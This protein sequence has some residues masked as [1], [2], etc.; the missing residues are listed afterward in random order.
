M[1]EL[2]TRAVENFALPTNV[3]SMIEESVNVIPAYSRIDAR[4][5]DCWSRLCSIVQNGPCVVL[6]LIL[7]NGEERSDFEP[8]QL[9]TV[10]H[11]RL[12]M[13][14]WPV[15]GLYPDPDASVNRADRAALRGKARAPQVRAQPPVRRGCA[16]RP[17]HADLPF[18]E[19]ASRTLEY[20][21]VDG[22]CVYRLHADGRP[23]CPVSALKAHLTMDRS[24]PEAEDAAPPSA[25]ELAAK[26][27]AS[28]PAAELPT[29]SSVAL[30]KRPAHET[31]PGAKSSGD[32]P[33]LDSPKTGRGTEGP[34]PSR[35]PSSLP[36][37][38]GD[39]QE[40]SASHAG[41]SVGQ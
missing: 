32:S 37:K 18:D 31:N 19:T 40:R 9:I 4:F 24:L 39:E 5:G 26:P 27:S 21:Y 30:G 23:L 13:D 29:A 14:G 10:F 25:S 6:P 2:S 1:L 17:R 34:G 36:T 8:G 3:R 22:G 7:I 35:G 41:E 11:G 20:G 28:K 38:G 12:V 33:T 16:V 15:D